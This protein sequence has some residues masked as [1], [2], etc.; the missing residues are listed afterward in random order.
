MEKLK[1]I[2]KLELYR[3]ADSSAWINTYSTLTDASEKAE[4]IFSISKARA[5]QLMPFLSEQLHSNDSDTL[6]GAL[7]FA[8]GQI[9][10]SSS[11]S[12]LLQ[13]SFDSFSAP[14]KEK[15]LLA[16]RQC[17]TQKSHAFFID[18]I[19]RG[20]LTEHALEAFS[21]CKRKEKGTAFF[22][23]DT[24]A[25][26]AYY[27]NYGSFFKQIPFLVQVLDQANP[28][29]KKYLLKALLNKAQND[30][31]RFYRILS[32][33]SLMPT[34]F[35]ELLSQSISDKS[36]WRERLYAIKLVPF[37]KDS[38][39]STRLTGFIDHNNVHLRFAAIEARLIT[40]DKINA[41]SLLLTRLEQEKH[42]YV[43]GKLL[44]LLAELNKEMAF[45]IIMQD[46][47]KGDD[48]YKALLIDALVKTGSLPA[49]RTV[50]Q[51]I[52]IPSP[53]L[54]NRAFENLVALRKVYT[55]DWKA[56]LESDSFSSVSLAL[57]YAKSRKQ[58]PNH[59]EVLAL[60]NK[61]NQPAEFEVQKAALAYFTDSDV[62]Q[63]TSIQRKLWQG[64]SHPFMQRLIQTR[65]AKISWPAQEKKSYSD[66]IPSFLCVDSLPEYEKNPLILIKTIRGDI[67]CELF[68]E[69]TPFTV[70]N[71]TSLIRSGF[72]T[73]LTFHRVIADFVI[74]GGDPLGDGWGG[75][76]YLV[77][78]EDNHL[79]F[80]R[81]SLGIAT[82]GFDTGSCQFFICQS[83]QP[84]LTG[85]YTNFGQVQE[86]LSVVDQILPGD[87]ILEIKLLD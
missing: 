54:A 20:I 64:A 2:K 19:N 34:R 50:R 69:T 58:K 16:L 80:E 26:V 13:I 56:L 76:R 27:A 86:G 11:E 3:V 8:I 84:H 46:L 82:S 48:N 62:E 85:N 65:F 70:Q 14:L 49:I 5:Q 15:Y 74:Q 73:N 68:P 52:H 25:Q 29:Q 63:D 55:K 57:E 75:T 32:A 53:I 87:K 9:A 44:G 43:R 47:D 38:L 51:F 67:T 78:S 33:D 1:Q 79:P 39:L 6:L 81:G 22:P 10:D 71:F 42:L 37:A 83:E 28:L 21:I 4:L 77:P 41:T 18:L 31:S 61:F 30:S 40:L 35:I 36:D 17:G 72:Y 45:R 24:T 12:T 7:F 23:K 60:Y 59:N 66:L